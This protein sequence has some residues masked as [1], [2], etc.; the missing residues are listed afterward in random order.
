MNLD[1]ANLEEIKQD[2][3]ESLINLNYPLEFINN[4]EL[5]FSNLLGPSKHRYNLIEWLLNK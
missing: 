5:L 1:S 3:H 2:I 4:R